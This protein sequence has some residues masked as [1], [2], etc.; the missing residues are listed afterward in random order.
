[1]F[2]IILALLFLIKVGSN[3]IFSAW[4]YLTTNFFSLPLPLEVD[5]TSPVKRRVVVN[6]NVVVPSVVGLSVVPKTSKYNKNYANKITLKSNAKYEN[7]FAFYNSQ[8]HAL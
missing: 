1:M 6:G 7:N 5:V 8:Q 4:K 3:S 2:H